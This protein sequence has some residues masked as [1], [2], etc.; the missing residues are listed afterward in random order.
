MKPKSHILSNEMIK[1][2]LDNFKPKGI[3]ERL[4]LKVQ[5]G[6]HII[7]QIQSELLKL[8]KRRLK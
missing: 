6:T 5:I 1:K 2:S 3:N 7:Q 4:R 8:S